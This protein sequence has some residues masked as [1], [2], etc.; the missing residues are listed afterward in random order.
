M[1]QWAEFEA[2]AAIS[3]YA[4]EHPE[5]VFPEFC[6]DETSFDAHAMGHPLLPTTA[7]VPNEMSLRPGSLRLHR[8]RLEHGGQGALCCAP[9][10]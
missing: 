3:G 8:E 1:A 5:D 6:A 10:D 4:Y 9:S 7:S 2:L